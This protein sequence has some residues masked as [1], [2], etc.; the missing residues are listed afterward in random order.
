MRFT[1]LIILLYILI[2]SSCKEHNPQL[3]KIEGKQIAITDSISLNK[4]IES[5]IAPYRT[6]INKD[7]DSVLAYALDNYSKSDGALNTA[8]GNF[9]ADAVFYEAN[10]IFNSRTGKHID[11]VLL[12]HG[13]IR[14]PISKGGISI[15]NVYKIMPFEN[16]I[17]IVAIKGSQVKAIV[18]YLS[19]SKRAHPISKQLQ[20]T[21]DENFK[22]VKATINNQEIDDNKTYYV[23]TSDYL[24]NGGD[25]MSFFK[26]NDSLY[27]LNYKIRHALIDNLKKVDT[28]NIKADNRLIQ[29]N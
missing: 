19:R 28:L 8:I 23:A 4:D 29:I 25:R 2:F 18:E 20:I 13:G 26:P 15:R 22:V 24:Y 9:M 27:A 16:S 12:N 21:L 6:R 11:M 5:F 3:V 14:A 17:V 10:P 1:H 7:L